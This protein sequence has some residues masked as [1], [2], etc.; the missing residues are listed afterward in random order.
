[1]ELF[2]DWNSD[3]VIKSELCTF[4]RF[5]SNNY[6]RDFHRLSPSCQ[7]SNCCFIHHFIVSDFCI[8]QLSTCWSW[9]F[10]SIEMNRLILLHR[11]PW[12]HFLTMISSCC[13]III[14]E[15]E[16]LNKEQLH[17][18]SCYVHHL[19]VSEFISYLL[20]HIH[21]HTRILSVPLQ[22]FQMTSR[23]MNKLNPCWE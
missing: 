6:D 14:D 16:K 12:S 3:F 1:V 20:L 11:L 4:I 5:S 10:K 21:R 23:K 7:I 22:M 8:S 17:L 9:T 19:V 18:F 15:P 2:V 13:L